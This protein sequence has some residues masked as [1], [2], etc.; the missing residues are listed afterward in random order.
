MDIYDS[1]KKKNTFKI[2]NSAN[3]PGCKYHIIKWLQLEYL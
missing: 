3:K 1:Y 2:F